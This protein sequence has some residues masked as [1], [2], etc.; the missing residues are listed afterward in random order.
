MKQF[1]AKILKK[2]FINFF[3]KKNHIN[4]TTSNI[5]K[6]NDTSLLFINAGMV[7]FKNLFLDNLNITKQQ[8]KVSIQKCIRLKDINNVGKTH[9][10]HT[11]FE[12]LGN[13]SFGDYFK[14]EAIYYAWQFLTKKLK[15]NPEYLTVTVHTKDEETY[16]IWK[17]LIKLD[18]N[19][20]IKKKTNFWK[21]DTKTGPCG[22]C[23]E[24]F[25]CKK[26]PLELWNLVFIEYYK[27]D[28]KKLIKLKKKSI[29]TGMG[30]ERLLSIL[31]KKDT[32]YETTLFKYT[33]KFLKPTKKNTHITNKIMDHLR[34]CII[35]IENNIKPT[36]VHRGYILRKLLRDIF[37]KSK[38]ILHKSKNILH[39][40]PHC[41]K[42]LKNSD[43]DIKTSPETIANIIQK[44][45]IIYLKNLK[46]AKS[47][48]L[49][50]I[51]SNFLKGSDI[52]T[53]Y[54]TYGVTIET[55]KNITKEL[56]TQIDLKNFKI[57]LKEM[58]KK[59]RKITK[60]KLH[61]N[62]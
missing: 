60:Q 15:L 35:L 8:N 41:L 49:K 9:Y 56:N 19:K 5:I 46:T 37:E 39:I 33:R 23:S 42:D 12:M 52:Y 30:F 36:S 26:K 14:K 47:L 57:Q 24:I 22:F 11:F 58:Q 17:N 50:K 38:K 55:I 34:C 54:D 45:L 6:K 29:D 18:T 13:F 61:I 21:M 27:T 40:L 59:N 25:Y 2:K 10:H 43:I 16:N 62:L 51:Q 28:E 31:Q 32:T 3:V 7:P 20:I 4:C 53:L 48:I 1:T 44:E